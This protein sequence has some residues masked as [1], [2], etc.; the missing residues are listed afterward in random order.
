MSAVC[1]KGDKSSC[2]CRFGKT[3]FLFRN[4]G[5]H[6]CLETKV[7]RANNGGDFEYLLAITKLNVLH[8]KDNGD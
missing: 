2:L 1:V 6:S 3:S 4:K 8:C 5:V 7:C